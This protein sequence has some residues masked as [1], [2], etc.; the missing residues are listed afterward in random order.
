MEALIRQREDRLIVIQ[1][2]SDFEADDPSLL[3]ELLNIP[4]Q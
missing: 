2:T 1:A 4:R 3:L